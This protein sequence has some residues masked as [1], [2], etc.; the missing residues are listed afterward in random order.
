[1]V[2]S[3]I[4]EQIIKNVGLNFLNLQNLFYLYS[5]KKQITL[6]PKP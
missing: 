3:L 2:H 5:I 1:M 6:N 4:F